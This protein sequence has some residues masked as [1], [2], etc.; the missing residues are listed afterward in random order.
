MNAPRTFL[1]L[2]PFY[3]GGGVM[4]RIAANA[5]F[6]RALLRAE[7]FDA[8]HFFLPSAQ[9]CRTLEAAL[10]QDGVFSDKIRLLLRQDLPRALAEE[11]YYCAHLSDCLTSLPALARLRRL[12]APRA[13]PV[14]GATHTL[15]YSRFAPLYL[16]HLWPGASGREAIIGTS[17]AALAML[18]ETFAWLREGYNLPESTHPGPALAHIPLG[19]DPDLFP[20]PDPQAKA[21]ARQQ[22]GLPQDRWTLLCFGRLAPAHKFDL[23]PLLRAV[24]RGLLPGGGLCAE[25]MTLLLAGW[26]DTADHGP[27]DTW[28]ALARNLGLHVHLLKR[29]DAARK[30]A[31]FLAADCFI[32]PADSIQE[33]FGLT[34]LEAGLAGLPVIASDFDGYRDLI[35]PEET[36]ILVPSI[37]FPPSP[38]LDALG[39]VLPDDALHL[40]LGQ[41]T[42]VDVP[43]L[44]LALGRLYADREL[45]G[46]LGRA[47][48]ERVLRE[49]AWP[50]VIARYCAVWEAQWRTPEPA[51]DAAHPLHFPYARLFAGHPSHHLDDATP[52][53][54][55]RLGEAIAR[56][57]DH[58]QQYLGLEPLLDADAVRRLLV[59]SRTTTPAGELVRRIMD[60]GGHAEAVARFCLH[61]ALKQDILEVVG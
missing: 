55:T 35:V 9:Q 10:R 23:P 38:D 58:P 1:T 12:H 20:P 8:C 13:F 22:L 41:Q 40:L 2:D 37:G 18:R 59:L 11:R 25:K 26:T 52:V 32:S 3:E 19:V 15:S 7:V 46:R 57:Q 33:T 4:G 44:A 53:R 29:P 16:A 5:G 54:R 47:G 43:A 17:S 61:W 49:F 45:G 34:L 6:L 39:Q 30:Q 48:R 24:Q 42:V 56:G 27:A 51:G 14:T 50:A 28:A 60:D 31:C 21:A 36:G